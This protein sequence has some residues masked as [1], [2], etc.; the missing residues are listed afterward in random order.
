MTLLAEPRGPTVGPLRPRPAATR[1]TSRPRPGA[2]A[3]TTSACWC[4]WARPSRST[5]ASPTWATF[6][7]RGDLVVVNTSATVPAALDGRLCRR[8]SRRRPRLRRAARRPVAGRGPPTRRGRHRA[9]GPRRSAGRSRWPM[10]GRSTCSPPSPT[11]GGCGSPASS[12]PAPSPTTS[13][14]HGRPIRYR[15]VGRD[16]PLDAYQTVFSTEPGSAEMPSAARPFTPE[17]VTDL[18]AGA[19]TSHPS[20]LHTG[21]SSLEGHETPYPER[22]RVPPATARLV[23]ATHAAGRPGGRHRHHRRPGARD[24]HRPRRAPRTPARA[25]PRWSSP[26][27]GACGPSTAC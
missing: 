17:V 11:R 22:Y 1:P 7:D 15:Y 23:N 9:A 3:G 10:A 26:P 16:W 4:R 6:L 24:R 5:P 14:A 18:V 13:S 27:S 12:W 8:A 2:C 25:G 20:L 21:V 19:S